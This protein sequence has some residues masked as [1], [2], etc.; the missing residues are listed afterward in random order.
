[1]LGACCVTLDKL[2]SLSAFSLHVFFISLSRDGSF[3]FQIIHGHKS[4]NTIYGY[5]DRNVI[6]TKTDICV[7]QVIFK[8]TDLPC[9]TSKSRTT[10]SFISI[11]PITRQEYYPFHPSRSSWFLLQDAG[12]WSMII[13]ALGTMIFIQR[14]KDKPHQSLNIVICQGKPEH[15]SSDKKPQLPLSPEA[16]WA[17][18]S[19][20]NCSPCLPSLSLRSP[21]QQNLWRESP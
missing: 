12:W 21:Y 16:P 10:L 3:P 17:M 11:W 20:P 2:A 18:S 19:P 8:G 7:T 4:Q 14:N 9:L 5:S 6:E 1:M 15:C 13:P